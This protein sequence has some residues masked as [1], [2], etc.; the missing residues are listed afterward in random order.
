MA[1]QAE[2]NRIAASQE[3]LFST[4][5]PVPQAIRRKFSLNAAKK[6]LYENMVASGKL[7]RNGL[8]RYYELVSNTNDRLNDDQK[9]ALRPWGVND[10]VFRPKPPRTLKPKPPSVPNPKRQVKLGNYL[11]RLQKGT[12]RE[13]NKGNKGNNRTQKNKSG[14]NRFNLMSSVLAKNYHDDSENSVTG[15]QRSNLSAMAT[16]PTG[17]QKS[18][19]SRH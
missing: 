17:V 3:T 19:E 4:F 7:S 6:Q 8:N 5:N 2:L 10:V 15:P 14:R 18:N 1:S 16:N 13:G 11:K 12:V 9:A